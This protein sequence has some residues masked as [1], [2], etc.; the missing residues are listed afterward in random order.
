MNNLIEE[1]EEECI[2][3]CLDG[4]AGNEGFMAIPVSALKGMELF[5]P[6]T[7]VAVPLNLINF[8]LHHIEECSILEELAFPY[9]DNSHEAF[10]GRMTRHSEIEEGHKLLSGL[11]EAG[12]M[13]KGYLKLKAMI[14]HT[15]GG[16]EGG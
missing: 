10:V 1:N 16:E 14:A 6:L 11:I 12:R 8:A 7:H 4:F 5:D 13:P 3:A 2:L 15:E 9:K